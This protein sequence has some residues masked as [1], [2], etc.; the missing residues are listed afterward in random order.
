MDQTLQIALKY[1]QAAWRRRW[2]G[3]TVAW[4]VCAVGWLGV[5]FVPNEYQAVA[6]I[7]VDTDAVLTPLLKGLAVD[8]SPDQQVAIMQ[9]TLLSRPNLQDLI[10]RT[11]LGLSV[12]TPTQRA[13][14]AK[15]LANEIK[16][17]MSLTQRNLFSI[18][19]SN[20]NPRLARDVVQTL[21]TIFTENATASNRRDMDNAQQFLAREVASYLDQLHVLEQERAQFRSQYSSILPVDGTG[22]LESV[23]AAHQAQDHAELALQEAQAMQALEEKELKRQFPNGAASVRQ[24]VAGVATPNGV[25]PLAAAE[26]RLRQMEV[27][28]TDDY[29]GVIEL[30]KQIAALKKLP[31]SHGGGTVAGANTPELYSQ[32]T[33]K[34]LDTQVAVS[35]A[36]RELAI[37]KGNVDRLEKIR[38][39]QPNLLA[40]LQNMDNNY[41]V[42]QRNYNELLARLQAA[43]LSQAADTQAEKV[44]LRIVDPPEVPLVPSGPNRPLLITAVLV[45]GILTGGAVAIALTLLDTSFTTMDELHDL[46]VPVLGSLPTAGGRPR[47]KAVLSAAQFAFGALLLILAYGGLIA[48]S[49]GGTV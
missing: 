30:K 45:F 37:A 46:G 22:A 49:V 1:A 35:S 21:L 23:S 44:H 33:M 9:Q 20:A 40:K 29:P 16:V 31:A 18:S 5:T 2:I 12:S 4:L 43:K 24:V 15:A 6:R 32:M 25:S 42:L 34:L 8:V 41:E 26:E 47:R 27:V 48:H 36:Q 10:S 7:Y 14:L 39:Q 19:Y 3:M 28:Y 17:T 13:V 38:Q 11:D